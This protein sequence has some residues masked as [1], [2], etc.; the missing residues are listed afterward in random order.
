MIA[1]R[2]STN[3]LLSDSLL[4]LM[5]GNGENAVVIFSTYPSDGT[6][7]LS[8]ELGKLG[9]NELNVSIVELTHLSTNNLNSETSLKAIPW[10]IF[11]QI[12]ESTTCIEEPIFILG[13][14]TRLHDH[15]M[16]L[17]ATSIN[18]KV[19]HADSNSIVELSYSFDSIVTTQISKNV[20]ATIMS[21]KAKALTNKYQETEWFGAE[22]IAELGGVLP[23]GVNAAT[24]QIIIQGLMEKQT[25][26]DRV[27]YRLTTKGWP[28]ALNYWTEKRNNTTELD[29]NKR[30]GIIFGRLPKI[31]TDG[32]PIAENDPALLGSRSEFKLIEYLSTMKPLDGF[33][34]I[35]QRIDD[36]YEGTQV[37]TL[38]EAIETFQEA[39]FIGDLRFAHEVLRR[40]ED[41]YIDAGEHFFI[42]NPKVN[43]ETERMFTNQLWS[44]IMK[45]ENQ[46]S[47]HHWTIDT[48]APLKELSIPISKFALANNSALSYMM[49]NRKG[50]GPSGTS[51]E[52]SP[53]SRAAHRLVVPN[54]LALNNS[55]DINIYQKRFLIGMLHYEEYCK[56]DTSIKTTAKI[57]DDI[58]LQLKEEGDLLEKEGASWGEIDN[59]IENELKSPLEC[60]IRKTTSSRVIPKL[61]S[62]GFISQVG[63]N[64]TGARRF[65]LTFD[66]RFIAS[67]LKNQLLREV[68]A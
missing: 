61:I 28:F 19:A 30:L 45:Y 53:F 4:S 7:Q 2:P 64:V 49:K 6:K 51:V 59:F 42:L 21:L 15:L 20:L 31:V 46:F 24:Q 44:S 39:P 29:I 62:A 57:T 54:N 5:K 68:L 25:S 33:I 3:N 48:T 50:K 17:A 16:W 55:N 67:W 9:F 58:F 60:S 65:D 36:S 63:R 27:V 43:E 11:N 18:A 32:D 10:N 56:R 26:G 12:I 8:D 47:P 23:K 22:E 52:K 40:Q 66:G 38:D 41:E 13:R 34:S 37:M 35:I 1:P 14:S